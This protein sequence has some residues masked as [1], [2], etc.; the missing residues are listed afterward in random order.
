MKRSDSSTHQDKLIR[1]IAFLE[2]FNSYYVSSRFY[3]SSDFASNGSRDHGTII[4]NLIEGKD[5]HVY[6][7]VL[8]I[9][10][11][12]KNYIVVRLS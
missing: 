2:N 4:K 5:V 3:V 12:C 8:L 10:L 6:L 9:P 11:L 1:P 7:C